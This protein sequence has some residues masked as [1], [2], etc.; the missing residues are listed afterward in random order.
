MCVLGA[1]AAATEEIEVGSAIFVPSLRNLAWALKQVAT[2]QLLARG[3][4][5]LGVGL[6][7]PATRSTVSPGSLARA[8]VGALVANSAAAMH[9]AYGFPAPRAEQLAIGGTPQRVADAVSRYLDAGAVRFALISDVL[10]WSESWP[11]LAQVRRALLT[12]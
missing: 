9:S 7:A 11:M 6:G 10:P 12:G 3:R 1:A 8:S 2:L 5:Q 4:F